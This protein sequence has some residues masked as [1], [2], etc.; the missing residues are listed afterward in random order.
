MFVCVKPN[1]V[2]V[3]EIV[4]DGLVGNEDVLFFFHFLPSLLVNM[5]S[6]KLLDL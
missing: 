4:G 6:I 2:F 3:V 1:N 5:I